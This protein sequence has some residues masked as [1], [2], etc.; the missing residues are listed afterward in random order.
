MNSVYVDYECNN[1]YDL[2]NT[3]IVYNKMEYELYLY[4]T[5]VGTLIIFLIVLYHFLG[6]E[7][8][9]IVDRVVTGT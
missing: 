4:C 1:D 8:K 9:P 6:N 5:G 7:D 2:I 3:Y